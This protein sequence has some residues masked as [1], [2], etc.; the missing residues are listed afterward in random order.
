KRS[1]VVLGGVGGVAD[2]LGVGPAEAEVDHLRAL[3]RGPEDAVR[4]IHGGAQ[5]AG[6][7]QHLHEDDWARESNA[8]DADAVVRRCAGDCGNVSS[9][10]DVVGRGAGGAWRA[11]DAARAE[12]GTDAANKVLVR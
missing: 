1:V 3:L 8:R 6:G 4:D 12:V 5:A 10:A 11:V 9:V 7:P 2:R